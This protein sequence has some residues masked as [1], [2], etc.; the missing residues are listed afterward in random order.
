MA[1]IQQLLQQDVISLVEYDDLMKYE[2]SQYEREAKTSATSNTL[3]KQESGGVSAENSDISSN[4]NNCQQPP[5]DIKVRN[6]LKFCIKI[7][8]KFGEKNKNQKKYFR[9]QKVF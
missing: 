5:D 8:K 3:S 4:N 6:K 1:V 9:A 2:D 7:I